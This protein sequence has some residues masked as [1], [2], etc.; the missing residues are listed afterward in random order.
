[1]SKFKPRLKF[2][3][4]CGKEFLAKGFYV[5][6]CSHNCYSKMNKIKRKGENNPNWNGGTSWE[7]SN[8]IANE[9]LIQ[10]CC[11]CSSIKFLCIHH[12]D[13]NRKNN[14]LDNL[15]IV[16]KSCH[17]KIHDTLKAWNKGNKKYTYIC[18]VCN[19]TFKTSEKR[20]IYCSRK[21][22]K[23]QLSNKKVEVNKNA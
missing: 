18:P 3:K 16:C 20:T 1:M 2:C 19:K 17:T 4:G 22:W 9:N 6:Y 13:K 21:C 8:R 12:K 15:M 23:E 7:F 10:K 11:L 5:K 14:N